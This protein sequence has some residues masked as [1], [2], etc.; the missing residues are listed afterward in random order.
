MALSTGERAACGEKRFRDNLPRQDRFRCRAGG[1]GRR[2]HSHRGCSARRCLGAQGWFIAGV[3]GGVVRPGGGSVRPR[4]HHERE[5]FHTFSSHGSGPEQCVADVAGVLAK[6]E[7]TNWRLRAVLRRE[8]SYE[9]RPA[10][11]RVEVVL[12]QPQPAAWRSRCCN[13]LQTSAE[14]ECRL[15]I[16]EV[17]VDAVGQ[18]SAGSTSS[19][20][21][22]RSWLACCWETPRTTPTTTRRACASLSKLRTLWMRPQLCMVA[23][24]MVDFD[25]F[26]QP[27]LACFQV[28]CWKIVPPQE[29]Q[30]CR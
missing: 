2:E 20:T 19:W 29:L 14:P 16:F 22:W 26:D 8:D 7:L 15:S 27:S 28:Q 25:E 11:T 30:F 12:A 4:C 10:R 24:P 6:V 5:A 17:A 9:D 13:S 3:Q 18:V 23:K 21:G 1:V